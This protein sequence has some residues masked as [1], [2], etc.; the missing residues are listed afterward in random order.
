VLHQLGEAPGK[1]AASVSARL[2]DR[3]VSQLKDDRTNRS[4][5]MKRSMGRV[6]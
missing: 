2:S 1:D 6:E 4:S 5:V 3:L